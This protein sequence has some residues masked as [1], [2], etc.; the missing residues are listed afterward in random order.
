MSMQEVARRAGF[1]RAWLYRHFPD[2]DALVSAVLL[3]TDEA[4]WQAAR[5]HIADAS[6]LVDQV[7][8][9]IGFARAQ[10]PTELFLGLMEHEPDAVTA[11][12]ATGLRARL[13]EMSRFWH[14]YVEAAQARGEVRRD[15][16]VGQAAEWIF[17]IVLS[18]VTIPG[19]TFDADDPPELHEFFAT[20]LVR[21]LG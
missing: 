9:A 10:G 4:F 6:T 5:H 3:R 20:F 1:S 12:V 15:V 21:G 18:V 17:R 2:K 13:P 8:A 7:V 16:D 19:E 14:S 11:M